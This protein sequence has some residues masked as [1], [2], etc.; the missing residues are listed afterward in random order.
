MINHR[1]SEEET[2]RPPAQGLE[3]MGNRHRAE[4]GEGPS[5]VCC[6][7]IRDF[8]AFFKPLLSACSEAKV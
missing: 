1:Q 2:H 8:L 3:E 4:L 5:H 7:T 6:K